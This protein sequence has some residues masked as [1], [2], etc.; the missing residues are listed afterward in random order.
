MVV[1]A[2]RIERDN[3]LRP[4]LLDD[5]LD[6]VLDFEHVHVRQRA[7]I[8]MPEALFARRIVEP[9]KDRRV[10][11]EARARHAELFDAKR[12][13][14][15]DAANRRMRLS[16]FAVGR[17][18]EGDAGAAGA[19]IGERAAATENLIVWMSQNREQRRAL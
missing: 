3:H 1:P 2:V 18:D 14:I 9:Q 12:S 17:A 7:R 19:P 15:V 5:A 16:R 10:D 11:P 6:G 4:D 13:E 8:V